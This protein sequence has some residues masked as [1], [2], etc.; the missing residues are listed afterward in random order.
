MSDNCT[1]D[2]CEPLIPPPP[3]PDCVV[4]FDY[5]R[6]IVRYPEFS[7]AGVTPVSAALA[8][9]YFY[10]ATI[11]LDNTCDSI[12]CDASVGGQ[13]ERLLMMLTAHIANIDGAGKLSGAGEPGRVTNKAVG[14][15]SVAYGGL[16]G[17]NA[18]NAWFAQSPYGL[19][20][21]NATAAYRTFRYRVPY[22]PYNFP[23]WTVY[24]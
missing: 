7:P 21:W 8:Q 22:I 9:E 13:R 4:Q 2:S 20:F 11:Y 10:D 18:T 12:V 15:V 23:Y 24:R 5:N 17:F 16:D 1:D 6:W 14:P 19:D 3:V